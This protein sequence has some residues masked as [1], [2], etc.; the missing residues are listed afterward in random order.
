MYISACSHEV[1]HRPPRGPRHYLRLCRG[2][3]EEQEEQEAAKLHLLP[4]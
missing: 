2:Q 4:H 1:D 3:E